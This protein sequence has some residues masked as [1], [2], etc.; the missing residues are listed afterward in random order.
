MFL[1]LTDPDQGADIYGQWLPRA[2]FGLHLRLGQLAQRIDRA[3]DAGQAAQ[4]ARQMSA[5]FR[6]A[7]LETEK[8]SGPEMLTAFRKIDDLNR[9]KWILPFQKWQAPP[10]KPPPYDYEGRMIAWWIHKLASRYSW[11][12][13]YIFDEL[14]PEEAA[15]YLQEILVGE[16]DE[17]DERRALSELSYS[18]D[19]QSKTGRFR[20]TPR[21]GW[22]VEIKE[23]SVRIR[24]DMLPLGHVVKLGDVNGRE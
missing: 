4:A 16:Y 22:M 11:T 20:P 21:P 14:W 6:L 8:L 13:S 15:A 23:K 12:R 18:F 17:A 10:G 19:K 3:L 7:G 2:R 24:R 1:E 9:L 5:Y